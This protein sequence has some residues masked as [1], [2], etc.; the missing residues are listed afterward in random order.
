MGVFIKAILKIST[1]FLV[2][3]FST[4][5]Y[6][7]EVTLAWDASSGGPQGYSIYYGTSPGVFT[8]SVNVGNVTEYRNAGERVY[9]THRANN[10]PQDC[11]NVAIR[12]GFA[13]RPQVW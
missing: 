1:P 7:A 8:D 3:F 6:A 5:S 2:L 13:Q 9:Q 10:L 12:L 4:F 11:M